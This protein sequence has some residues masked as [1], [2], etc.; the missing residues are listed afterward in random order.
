MGGARRWLCWRGSLVADLVVWRLLR[1]TKRATLNERRALG[2]CR[3]CAKAQARMSSPFVGQGLVADRSDRRMPFAIFSLLYVMPR[4][5]RSL[6]AFIPLI[7]TVAGVCAQSLPPPSRTVFKCEEG[8]KTVYSDAPCVGAK[9]IDV[10]PTRGVSKLSGRERIGRDV[11]H[12]QF[13]E[14]LSEAI[15]PISGMRPRQFATFERRTKLSAEAQRECQRLDVQMP[16]VEQEELQASGQ[17][18]AD[19]Q[20]RLFRLRKRFRELGC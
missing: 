10:E 16:S 1:A 11:Q 20:G 3:A 18:L 15:R 8:G 14:Q 6:A 7:L 12:E 19:V 13:R 4:I 17:A 5:R 2:L 9:K